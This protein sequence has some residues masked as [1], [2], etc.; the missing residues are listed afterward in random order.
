MFFFL[1]NL[2]LQ[3]NKL[4]TRGLNS[5]FSP[6]TNMIHPLIALPQHIEKGFMPAK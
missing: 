6:Q 5:F 1:S 3:P 2:L 4:L